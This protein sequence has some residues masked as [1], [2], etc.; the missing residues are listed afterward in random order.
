MKAI[1]RR[2]HRVE[3]NFAPRENEQGERLAEL[4]RERRRR[5]LEGMEAP[6]EIEAVNPLVIQVAYFLK[7]SS[8]I[9]V[10]WPTSMT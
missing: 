4:V 7:W 10:Y 8:A 2:L 5:R 3:E 9:C 1:N 6:G